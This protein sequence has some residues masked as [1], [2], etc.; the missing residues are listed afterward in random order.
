M[1]TGDLKT[2]AYTSINEKPSRCVG[3]DGLAPA[4][5]RLEKSLLLPQVREIG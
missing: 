3:F 5:E 1:P 2:F 4:A